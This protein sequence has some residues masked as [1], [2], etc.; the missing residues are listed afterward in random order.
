MEQVKKDVDK[1][2]IKEEMVTLKPSAMCQDGHKFIHRSGIEVVCT[3]CPLGY[4][5]TPD[6]K[7]KDGHIYAGKQ[8]LI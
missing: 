7:I 8:L 1:L 6:M 2:G 5:F 3:D 4:M